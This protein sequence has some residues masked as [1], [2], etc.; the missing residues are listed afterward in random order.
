MS[1]NHD[2]VTVAPL[3][4]LS[5]LDHYQ[6]TNTPENKRCVGVILGDAST[7][8]FRVTNSFA[9]PLRRT[10]RTQMCGSWITITSKI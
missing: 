1:S 2:K 6:R 3:V 5:V 9:L 8:T 7:D 4:L 10:R